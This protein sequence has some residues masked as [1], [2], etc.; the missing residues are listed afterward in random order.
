MVQV[1]ILKFLAVAFPTVGF[2]QIATVGTTNSE[3]N[4]R[5]ETGLTANTMKELSYVRMIY[6][7]VTPEPSVVHSAVKSTNSADK[8]MQFVTAS[9][10]NSSNVDDNNVTLATE[11]GTGH[12]IDDYNMTKEPS[13]TYENLDRVVQAHRFLLLYYPPIIIFIGCIGNFL[14]V[15]VMVQRR[16]LKHNTCVYMV[17]LSIIGNFILTLFAAL[18]VIRNFYPNSSHPIMC[19]T[20]NFIAYCLFDV[21]AWI[22]VAMTIDRFLAVNFPLRALSWRTVKRTKRI[23]ISIFIIVVLKNIHI[24]FTTNLLYSNEVKSNICTYTSDK[25]FIKVVNW[26]NTIIGA[27]LPFV[28]LI[29]AN[30]RIL[31]IIKRQTQTS[32]AMQTLNCSAERESLYQSRCSLND[33]GCLKSSAYQQERRARESQMTIQLIM[34]NFVFLFF[35]LPVFVNNTFWSIHDRNESVYVN[36][37]YVLTKRV[38][39]VLVYTN[40]ATYFYIY[41]IAGCKFRQDLCRLF[42]CCSGANERCSIRIFAP[43]KVASAE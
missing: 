13:V 38:C 1:M 11:T 7:N 6:R 41:C 19:K 10:S 35:T 21:S 27:V 14:I 39:Q 2:A 23:I 4:T 43:K 36:A 42:R 17:V 25:T 15:A 26:L 28:I 34:V 31:Y 20:L 5:S 40:S 3:T 22:L 33:V 37:V 24:F 16:H 8:D 9:E 18:W 29:T 12:A 30:A 32:L